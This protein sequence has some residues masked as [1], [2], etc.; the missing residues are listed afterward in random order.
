MP[1]GDYVLLSSNAQILP[2]LAG[3]KGFVGNI[4]RHGLHKCI[5]LSKL[6]LHIPRH[7]PA[8]AANGIW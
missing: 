8:A 5:H 6:W 1:E 2:F 3:G 4:A 7:A